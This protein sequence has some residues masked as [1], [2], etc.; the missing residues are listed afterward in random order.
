LILLNAS[1]LFIISR[2]SYLDDSDDNGEYIPEDDVSN[3]E[4]AE[5]DVSNN[6]DEEVKEHLILVR[7]VSES[8]HPLKHESKPFPA[9]LMNNIIVTDVLT[10][11]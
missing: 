2:S 5:D 6:N 8:Y 9:C 3:N 11:I 10:E 7:S 4:D 1:K